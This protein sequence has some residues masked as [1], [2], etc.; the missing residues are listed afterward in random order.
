[1]VVE[2]VDNLIRN[3]SMNT[4]LTEQGVNY[5]YYFNKYLSENRVYSLNKESR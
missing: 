4:L 1:M 2:N 3:C 5:G